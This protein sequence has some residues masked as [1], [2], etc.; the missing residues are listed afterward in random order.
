MSRIARRIIVEGRVTGVGFRYATVRQAGT[1]RGALQG[2]VRNLDS[3]TV[4]CVLQGE[5]ADVEAMVRWLEHGPPVAHVVSCRVTAI[6]LRENLPPF[7]VA[8]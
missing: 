7:D 6:P 3:R 2:C 4:E 1:C 8:F 5:E